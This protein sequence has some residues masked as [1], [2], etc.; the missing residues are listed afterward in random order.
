MS[1]IDEEKQT[2]TQTD[3]ETDLGTLLS[4]LYP[5]PIEK[6]SSAPHKDF[7]PLREALGVSLM[8]DDNGEAMLRRQMQA[9]E[10][11]FDT[12]LAAYANSADNPLGCTQ[13][14]R[15]HLALRLQSH[16]LNTA[17]CLNAMDYMDGLKKNISK[18]YPHPLHN[19]EQTIDE[20]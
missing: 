9:L 18:K 8:P 19:D 16:C 7:A 10:A 6:K 5:H 13:S 4:A 17:R 12:T 2:D 14:A 11:L 3:L 1:D 20:A 15:I